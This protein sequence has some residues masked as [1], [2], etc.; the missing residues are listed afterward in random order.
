MNV[1]YTIV[2]SGIGLVIAS[3]I[4]Y[5]LV[6]LG[7]AALAQRDARRAARES[8][9][10]EAETSAHHLRIAVVVP[11]HNEELVL[12]ATLSSLQSQD[13]PGHLL[14]I[15][16]VAD[17]CKD[18]TAQIA[19]AH[20]VTVLER[21]NKEERGKGYALDW[22]ISQL[23][24]RSQAP[25]A[26]I[27]V[28][29]D[30]WVAPDFVGIMAARLS[31]DSDANGCC[32]LQGR[33]GVLNKADGWRS[34][35]MAGAFDLV[36]HI[37]P[38]G[39]DRLGL[40]LSLKGNGMAF[41]RQV[42]TRARWQGHS[43]TE[44][45]DYGL[46]LIRFHGIRVHYVP[47]ALVLAQMPVTAEQATSQRK[48]WEGGR[49]LLLR[50]RAL[51][52]LKE[53]LRKR[54]VQLFDA[55]IALFIPPLA[56]L[57]ALLLLWGALIALGVA[58]HLLLGANGFAALFALATLGFLTYVLGGFRVAGAPREVYSSLLKAPFYIV[59]KLALYAVGL[60][61]RRS[62]ASESQPEWVRTDRIAVATPPITEAHRDLA[63]TE[64]PVL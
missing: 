56:E 39:Y 14:E 64:K 15:V 52:L 21:F 47:E 2:V 1:F 49:Y 7:A 61:K 42:L 8:R 38:M 54:N 51:P 53:G 12:A 40:S 57:A 63:S 20:G 37:R 60:F 16:V 50:E 9:T 29:A 36:N 59:W 44:D 4:A 27:I 43:I 41:T 35:L 26:V 28:D 33:Y 34:A 31:A 3:C 48:R 17:N 55:A 24:A 19:R 18:T 10:P 6:L 32:A 45:M 23:L 46:D 62:R 13:Y 5:L 30:T 22:A 11:A 25:D 58:R